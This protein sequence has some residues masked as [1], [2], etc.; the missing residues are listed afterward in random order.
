MA[1]FLETCDS[2]VTVPSKSGITAYS[3]VTIPSKLGITAYNVLP[4][5]DMCHAAGKAMSRTCYH[6]LTCVM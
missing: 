6:M 3:D 1:N 2:D 5:A 4:H